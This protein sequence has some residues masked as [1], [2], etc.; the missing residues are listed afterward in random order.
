MLRRPFGYDAALARPAAATVRVLTPCSVVKTLA[1][2]YSP[3][4]HPSALTL[5]ATLATRHF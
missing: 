4:L 1:A 3:Q 2:G 5:L